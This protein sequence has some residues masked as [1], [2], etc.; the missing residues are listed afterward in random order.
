MEH[1]IEQQIIALDMEALTNRMKRL[2]L[3]GKVMTLLN[4]LWDGN[5]LKPSPWRTVE[6]NWEDDGMEVTAAELRAPTF[7]F[8]N[9]TKF[10]Q[11]VQQLLKARFRRRTS[12]EPNRIRIKADPN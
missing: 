9:E 6:V 2:E 12:H 4:Q 1:M 3:E 10:W 5:C 8:M 11:Q 7:Y